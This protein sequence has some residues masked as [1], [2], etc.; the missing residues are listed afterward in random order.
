MNAVDFVEQFK[1]NLYSK[2][3]FVFTPQGDLKSLPKGSTVLDF[4]FAI[5]TDIGYTTRGAKPM[6]IVALSR[7]LKSGDQVEIITSSTAKPTKTGWIMPLP[8][9]QE[10]NQVSLTRKTQTNC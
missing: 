7:V 4:A 10:P 6:E 2:E 1:L 9:E 3:I 5:H 8:P